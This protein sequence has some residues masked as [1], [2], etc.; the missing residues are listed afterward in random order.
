MSQPPQNASINPLESYPWYHGE[1]DRRTT[2]SA[3][4]KDNIV[5]YLIKSRVCHCIT[6][7]M[8]MS[9]CNRYIVCMCVRVCMCA[10]VCV[11]VCV[12]AYACGVCTCVHVY[13]WVHLCTSACITYFF[14]QDGCFIVRDPSKADEKRLG[15]YSLSIWHCGKTRHLRYVMLLFNAH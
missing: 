11:C 7:S 15:F 5:S 3:L 1:I 4:E 12:C 8:A 6:V 14:Q 2:E 13:E 10:C 9:M